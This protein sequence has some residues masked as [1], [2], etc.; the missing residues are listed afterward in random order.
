MA[1]AKRDRYT[2]PRGVAIFPRLNEPDTKFDADGI[3]SVRL[4]YEAD[5]ANFLALVKKLEAKRDEL[6]AQWLSENPKKKK[7]AE[8]APVF[9]EEL[10]ENGDETGRLTLNFKMK[11]KG[12]SKRTGKVF[13]MRPNFFDA[14]G[15]EL[16][17]PPNVG[18]GSVLKIGFEVWGSFVESAKKFYLSLRLQGVQVIELV[19]FGHRSAKDYGFGEEEG[20]EADE[21]ATTRSDDDDDDDADTSGDAGGDDDSGDY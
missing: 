10:D 13:E 3:F 4:A 21:S 16:V 6:F 14:R 8:V 9:A 7:V 1:Q 18:G 11:A 20:Y 15:V 5:D 2:S 17:N 19:E 12:K